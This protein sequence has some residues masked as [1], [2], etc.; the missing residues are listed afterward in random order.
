MTRAVAVLLVSTLIVP[1]ASAVTG[2]G[3]LEGRVVTPQGSAAP[4]AVW[5]ATAVNPKTPQRA[6]VDEKGTFRLD[7]VP[8]GAVELAVETAEGLYV[9]ETPVTL[10]PGA[11]RQV[12]L[13]LRGRQGTTPAAPSGTP[14]PQP[15]PKTQTDY[16]SAP[17][18][19]PPP[20]PPANNK[21][22]GT[23][24]DNPLTATLIV[25]GGAVV[26]GLIIDAVD[27]DNNN[28]NAASPSNP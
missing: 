16:P 19:T 11:T 26:T 17:S 15:P 20:Q 8:A 28:S 4:K 22:T 12:Q 10:A 7:A 5:A 13:A 2:S 24:W 9:V 3:I 25:I 14:P 6:T 1:P 21:K 27:D 23:L 18:S